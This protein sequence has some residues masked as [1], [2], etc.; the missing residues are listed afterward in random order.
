MEKLEFENTRLKEQWV[1]TAKLARAER[2]ITKLMCY[3]SIEAEKYDQASSDLVAE[4]KELLVEI[5]A[6]LSAKPE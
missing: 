5:R 4:A 2:I 3:V 1:P 6:V